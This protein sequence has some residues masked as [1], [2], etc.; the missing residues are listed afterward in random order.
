MLDVR[1]NAPVLFVPARYDSVDHNEVLVI[2]LGNIKIDST[3]IDFDPEMNYRL[4]N[5]PV[6]LYDAYNFLQ[7]DMQIM[8][9]TS[10]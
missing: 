6:M 5:N 10:L 3:L 1:L 4:V 2:D 9:F 8:T 7:R